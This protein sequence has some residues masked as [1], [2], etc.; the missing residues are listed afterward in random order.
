MS[1]RFVGERNLRFL[2]NNVFEIEQLIAHDYFGEHDR[3]IFDMVLEAALKLE[4]ELLH[5]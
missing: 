4:R 2:L 3:D 5:P 1:K